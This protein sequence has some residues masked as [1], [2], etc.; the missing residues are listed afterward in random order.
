MISHQFA[1]SKP[2]QRVVRIK[3]LFPSDVLCN[4]AGQV[5]IKNESC[6]R[7][8]KNGWKFK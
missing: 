8:W 1:A 2:A 5:S 7:V 3:M 4:E 6:Q